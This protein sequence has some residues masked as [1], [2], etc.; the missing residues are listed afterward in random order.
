MTATKLTKMDGKDVR[1]AS[2]AITNAGD[3]LSD[4][5]AVDPQEFHHGEKVYVV[6]ECEVAKVRFDPIKDTQDLRRIHFFR[7]GNATI[8]DESIVA[9]QLEEQARKIEEAAGIRRLELGN[10]LERQHK[11]G[12]HDAGLVDGCP[13]CEDTA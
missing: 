1:S 12:E 11:A 9:E 2:I 4:A 10:E 8:V 7:A 5:L 6:L 3:G 13:M